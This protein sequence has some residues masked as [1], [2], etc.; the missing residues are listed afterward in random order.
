[1]NACRPF[2]LLSS[3]ACLAA[4][5]SVSPASADETC[6]SPYVA[7]LIKGQEDYIHVWTLGVE[8]LGDG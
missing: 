7:N 5:L 2:T 1:M 3:A 6:N 8:N 4:A